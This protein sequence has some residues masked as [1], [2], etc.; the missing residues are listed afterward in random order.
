M[1]MICAL[2]CVSVP[3][4]TP[5]ISP[6]KNYTDFSVYT[7]EDTPEIR[8]PLQTGHFLPPQVPCLCTFQPLKLSNQDTFFWPNSV[9][10]RRVL[11]QLPYLCQSQPYYGL[12]VL[13]YYIQHPELKDKSIPLS[14]EHITAS[15]WK[16]LHVRMYVTCI[17]VL[18]QHDF[19]HS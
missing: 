19:P 18:Q 2:K 17:L 16:V 5:L 9:L 4:E 8:S 1:L 10:I 14:K 15:Q 3:P 11:V 13:Y 12:L 7:V 6:P